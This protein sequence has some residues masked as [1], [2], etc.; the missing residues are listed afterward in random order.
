MKRMPILLKVHGAKH[1]FCQKIGGG[2]GM[3]IPFNR[4]ATF[5]PSGG[6]PLFSFLR[7]CDFH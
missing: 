6:F 1:E 3:Q 5:P 7:I 4:G 2:G